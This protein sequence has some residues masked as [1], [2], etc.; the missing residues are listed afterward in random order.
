MNELIWDKIPDA[1]EI[2]IT[3]TDAERTIIEQ[4]RLPNRLNQ[5]SLRK[6]LD[7]APG[8]FLI[9]THL[10]DK[11]EYLQRNIYKE[12]CSRIGS[13][14][15]RYGAFYDVKDYG[16][17]Y[18]ESRIPV[19]QT[20]EST[21]FHTDSSA[22]GYYPKAVGLLCVR[23]AMAG[24]YSL[25]VNAANAYRH[26]IAKYR[27][28]DSLLAFAAIRDIVTPGTEFSIENL[29]RNRFP[30]L[31]ISAS[32]FIFRYM[33]YWLERGHLKAGEPL[34]NGYTEL[35]DDLDGFINEPTHQFS[36]LLEAGDILIFNNT[37]LLHNRTAFK[38]A[39]EIERERLLVR[40]WIDY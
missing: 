11:Q 9:R 20:H 12:C 29:K 4:G 18:R 17:D 21:G 35:L 8:F 40:A 38:N 37:F 26:L 10:S 6:Y 5:Q 1:H 27:E 3:F 32:K 14:N 36:F 31:E 23:P 25:L 33:R 39:T 30:I 34:P 16:G 24:G 22:A 28:Y 7:A 15:E 2:L 19:S 13:L